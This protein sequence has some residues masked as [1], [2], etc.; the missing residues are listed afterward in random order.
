MQHA[1]VTLVLIS[2]QRHHADCEYAANV[3]WKGRMIAS[4]TMTAPA[5]S[6]TN[7][8]RRSRR[9][10]ASSTPAVIASTLPA[11]VRDQRSSSTDTATTSI[12]INLIGY[13]CCRDAHRATA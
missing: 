12:A 1:H 8:V 5:S 9:V 13:T 10:R 2:D 6:R 11:T 7:R 3:G 4:A